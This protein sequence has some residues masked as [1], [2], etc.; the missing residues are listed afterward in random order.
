M[1]FPAGRCCQLLVP[2]STP[3]SLS[4]FCRLHRLRMKQFVPAV[5]FHFMALYPRFWDIGPFLKVLGHAFEAIHARDASQRWKCSLSFCIIVVVPSLRFLVF[6][7]SVRGIHF[8]ELRIWKK[9]IQTKIIYW[10]VIKG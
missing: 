3:H 7:P 10:A 8:R 2:N 9:F 4:S 1:Y 6:T 5:N